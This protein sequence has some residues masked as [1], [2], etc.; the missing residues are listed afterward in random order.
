MQKREAPIRRCA[1]P[2]AAHWPLCCTTHGSCCRSIKWTPNWLAF[3][4][5][6]G[7]T[8]ALALRTEE[9]ALLVFLSGH[10]LLHKA[11]PGPFQ[12]R[13]RQTLHRR[14]RHS[15]RSS[16]YPRSTHSS[17]VKTD[18]PKRL[19]ILPSQQVAVA[20]TPVHATLSGSWTATLDQ[21][22]AALQRAGK[23]VCIFF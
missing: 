22:S 4:P 9:A 19:K 5:G 13:R 17:L 23:I 15:I 16:H 12:T 2:L 20:A 8:I 3:R 14:G 10:F 18:D 21:C 6:A 11:S 7:A 1:G